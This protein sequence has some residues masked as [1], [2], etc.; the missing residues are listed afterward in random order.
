MMPSSRLTASMIR[1]P[2]ICVTDIAVL[3]STLDDPGF[4]K[5]TSNVYLD[6]QLPWVLLDDELRRYQKFPE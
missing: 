3:A 6:H 2:D 5:P 4:A 1:F